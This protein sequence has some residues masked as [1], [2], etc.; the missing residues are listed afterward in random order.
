MTLEADRGAL[1]AAAAGWDGV[2]DEVVAAQMELWSGN[3]Q[4]AQFGWFANRAGIDSQHDQF[5]TAMID[6]MS[7]GSA[8]VREIAEA[9]RRTAEDFGATDTSVADEFHNEDGTPR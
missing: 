7:T 3:G 5:I 9:L 4:G 6:A 2:A 1:V 8:K